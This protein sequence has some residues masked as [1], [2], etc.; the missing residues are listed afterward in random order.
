VSYLDY[1][2]L[3]NINIINLAVTLSVL[4][5]IINTNKISWNDVNYDSDAEVM[6]CFTLLG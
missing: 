3:V 2:L 4:F 5:I 1:K 6:S